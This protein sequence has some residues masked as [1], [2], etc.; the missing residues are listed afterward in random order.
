MII[1]IK[2]ILLNQELHLEPELIVLSTGIVPNNSDLMIFENI[3][4][5]Y[6]DS[7]FLKEANVKFRPVDMLTDG[8]FIAG[9]AHSPRQLNESIIQAQA[10]AGRALTIL[11]KHALPARRDTSEVN[12]RRC[13]GCEI[14]ITA[15][16]YHARV[17]D[18]DEKIAV[19]IDTLCQGCG[20]CAMVCPNG[21]AFLRGY[22]CGQVY[23]MIDAA[24][25]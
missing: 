23:S 3:G 14:C 11:N 21:A 7:K 1:K 19:V 16:P 6:T 10:T 18:T 2:D 9:L 5:E 25:D 24:A 13:S 20:V 22:K 4:L 17:L 8:I 15:C 12:T